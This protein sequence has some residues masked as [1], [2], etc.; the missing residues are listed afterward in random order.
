MSGPLSEASGMYASTDSE[1]NHV[2]T[3]DL[4]HI[5]QNVIW[6]GINVDDL[7]EA[8]P[9]CA[10]SCYNVRQVDAWSPKD[11]D[12][13]G[14][15]LFYQ[16]QDDAMSDF[17]RDGESYNDALD[18]L[19]EAPCYC[20]AC[21]E[22]RLLLNDILRMASHGRTRVQCWRNFRRGVHPF[23]AGPRLVSGSATV[24]WYEW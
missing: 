13:D 20:E 3:L 2:S 21:R 11:F 6:H 5:G 15:T 9:S 18:A 22:W 17:T 12:S 7:L 16:N 8:G 4:H 1:A 24:W 23:V 14:E 10:G 19:V